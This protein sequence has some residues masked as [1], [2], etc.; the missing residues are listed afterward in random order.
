MLD[1]SQ[2]Q[3]YPTSWRKRAFKIPI[4]IPAAD[5]S[6]SEDPAREG[7]VAAVVKKLGLLGEE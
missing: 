7:L 3:Q 6:V 4:P 1:S 5:G 2:A